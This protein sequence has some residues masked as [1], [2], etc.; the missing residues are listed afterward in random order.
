M[1]FHYFIFKILIPT[2]NINFKRIGNFYTFADIKKQVKN[3]MS[4][5]IFHHCVV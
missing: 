4:C 3:M 5:L 1:I 2:V